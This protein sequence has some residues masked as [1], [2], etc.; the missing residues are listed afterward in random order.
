MK[1]E[2]LESFLD[3]STEIWIEKEEGIFLEKKDDKVFLEEYYQD[4]SATIRYLRED[5]RCGLFYTTVLEEKSFYQAT[6][7]AK[8][9]S[10]YGFPAVYF[11]ELENS[12]YPNLKPQKIDIY[13][14]SKKLKKEIIPELEEL[15][16]KEK[17]KR[18]EK[19]EFSIAN[20]KKELY[21]KNVR[22]SWEE[23][24]FMMVISVVAEGKD[25]EASGYE[26]FEGRILDL[27]EIK[28][29][30][31]RACYKAKVL[32][33]TKKGRNLRV[34]VIFPPEIGIELLEILGFSFSGEEVVK[35]RSKLGN[36]IGKKV[37]SENLTIWDDGVTE[38]LVEAR[39]FDD[40]GAPQTRK[41]LVENGVVKGFLFDTYWKKEAH[42]LG[43]GEFVEGNARRPNFACSPKPSITNLYIQQGSLD[44]QKILSLHEEMFEVLE[45]LGAHTADPISGEF[46]F[47]VS[48]IYYKKGEPAEYFC[49]MALTGNIF[50]IFN[51]VVAVGKDLKFYGNLGAPSL[52]IESMDLGG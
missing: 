28:E 27:N 40:E 51:K 21:R 11:E 1:L 29:R 15:A 6:E 49:E 25:K 17:I 2:V 52:V 43:L 3:K 19:L 44:R 18:I 8:Y 33:G 34:P 4:Q 38:D 46:A 14:I 9:L 39:P 5:G 37:F 35:G 22:L 50:E 48:G 31:K 23:P 45:I 26:W 42:R 16:Y 12:H 13:E 24:N 47:G 41:L 10:N 32:S 30:V 7:K 20:L 36:S